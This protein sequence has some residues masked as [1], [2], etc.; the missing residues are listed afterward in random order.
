MLSAEILVRNKHTGNRLSVDARIQP[1]KWCLMMLDSPFSYWQEDQKIAALDTRSRRKWANLYRFVDCPR[2]RTSHFCK[3]YMYS[4][5]PRIVHPS[6]NTFLFGE[7][8]SF[9]ISR[10]CHSQAYQE[11]GES[12]LACCTPP[13]VIYPPSY[14]ISAKYGCASNRARSSSWGHCC[15]RRR[16]SS[17]HRFEEEG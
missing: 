14:C 1:R 3:L 6:I 4:Y 17:Q 7:I 8:I 12:E 13:S 9:Y 15:Y 10:Y 2:T 11:E 5:P 16:S